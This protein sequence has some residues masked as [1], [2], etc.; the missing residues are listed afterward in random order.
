MNNAAER[1]LMLD[2]KKIH[3][4]AQDIILG[5]LR[6]VIA[7]LSIKEIN[8]DREKFMHLVNENVAQEIN[9][10]LSVILGN[11]GFV[12]EELAQHRVQLKEGALPSV[13]NRR[14]DEVA[15][16]LLDLGSAASRIARVASD[17]QA[18]TRPKS[19]HLRHR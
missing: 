12:A 7:T 3:D 16:A 5:Q 17:L 4:Q 15:A 13:V 19:F 6:L 18:F 14:L 9:N 11:T 1:L 10:P 2:E 8:K